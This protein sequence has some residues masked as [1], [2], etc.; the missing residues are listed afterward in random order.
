MKGIVFTEFLEM[1]ES[2]FSPEVADEIIE[3]T[4]L[5]SGGAYSAVGTYDHREIVALVQRLSE[6]QGSSVPDLLKA[7]GKHLLRRFTEGYP[8]FFEGKSGAFEFLEDVENTVHVEV[9]K[10]YPEAE[11]PSFDTLRDGDVL[12]MTYRSPRRMADLAEGLIM[13][14]AEHFGEELSIE[15]EEVSGDGEVVR[16]TM[17]VTQPN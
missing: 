8:Q 12:V 3:T 9:L 14:C 16:F 2:Q 10:L 11:L 7:F 6:H 15:R 17:K 5:P 13:G 4:D 1:V